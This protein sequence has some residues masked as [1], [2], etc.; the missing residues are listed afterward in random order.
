MKI[1]VIVLMFLSFGSAFGY[2]YHCRPMPLREERAALFKAELLPLE[3]GLSRITWSY[4]LQKSEA[5]QW[6]VFLN[7]PTGETINRL[8]Y[9]H[10]IPELRKRQKISE[11]RYIQKTLIYD[12]MESYLKMYESGYLNPIYCPPRKPQA[13]Q[14]DE[15][16]AAPSSDHT[17]PF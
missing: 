14:N 6:E 3:A 13:V 7:G 1:L 12:K 8:H 17:L 9:G 16:Q 10:N 11:E 15:P 4:Q 2:E 5:D